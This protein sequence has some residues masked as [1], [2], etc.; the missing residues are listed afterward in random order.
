MSIR[1]AKPSRSAMTRDSTPSP[2]TSLFF[3]LSNFDDRRQRHDE[4]FV[5]DADDHAVEHCERERQA[6]AEGRAEA[7]TGRNRN[8]A[9]ERLNRA[10]GDVHPNATPGNLGHR[11]IGGE[12]WRNRRLSRSP[13]ESC[14]SAWIR[15]FSTALPRTFARSISPPSSDTSMTMGPRA[16]RGRKADLALLRFSRGQTRLFCLEPMINGVADHMRQRIG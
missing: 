11:R 3:G 4:S 2:C 9:A 5:G 10:L 16:M 1:G 12:P 13:S 14:A 15:S 8:A 7:R 6:H